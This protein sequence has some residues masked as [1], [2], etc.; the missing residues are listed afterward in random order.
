MYMLEENY[1]RNHIH[2][3]FGID[4]DLLLRLWMAYTKEGSNTLEKDLYTRAT[5]DIK[6]KTLRVFEEKSLSLA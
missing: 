2:S 3:R 1:S 6:L 4:K 5:A